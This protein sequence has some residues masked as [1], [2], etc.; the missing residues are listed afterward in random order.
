MAEAIIRIPLDELIIGMKEEEAIETVK[1]SLNGV[2]N[3][4]WLSESTDEY[5]VVLA[6]LVLLNGSEVDDN[7][8]FKGFADG[9]SLGNLRGTGRTKLDALERLCS[10]FESIV[11]NN[12]EI[13][14]SISMTSS[15]DDKYIYKVYFDYY[16][17][18]FKKFLV[19][20]IKTM[21][22]ANCYS[23][24]PVNFD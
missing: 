5:R 24:C 23:E 21:H 12:Y 16:E 19:R 7:T 14:C 13:L 8:R 20:H 22:S 18:V 4:V 3:I 9:I 1:V 11:S 6:D 2:G 15:I 17:R 10:Q